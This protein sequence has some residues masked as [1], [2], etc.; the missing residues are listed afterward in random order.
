MTESRY[1]IGLL[2]RVLRRE[3]IARRASRHVSTIAGV[4]RSAGGPKGLDGHALAIRARVYE[5]HLYLAANRRE[6]A[7]ALT[8]NDGDGHQ[9]HLIDKVPFQQ[10]LDQ[11]TASGHLQFAL[12]AGL[13]LGN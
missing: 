12:S 7:R 4:L 1:C 10:P 6:Q 9:L 2:L 5:R 8:K 13:E 11:A 3:P